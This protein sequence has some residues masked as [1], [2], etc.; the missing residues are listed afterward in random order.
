MLLSE[1]LFE[2][3]H[4]VTRNKPFSKDELERIE[5]LLGK[6]EAKGIK[7][8]SAK[9]LGFAG[10]MSYREMREKI[11]FLRNKAY[12]KEFVTIDQIYAQDQD[13]VSVKNLRSV[14]EAWDK[15]PL[16]EVLKIPGGYWL[17]EGHH[18]IALQ[19]LAGRYKIQVFTEYEK[20]R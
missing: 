15:A 10:E 6:L 2:T 7:D 20:K 11:G 3:E 5:M 12:K 14:L 18:R 13:G 17:I 19:R 4:S 1:L 8:I 9:V 16:P